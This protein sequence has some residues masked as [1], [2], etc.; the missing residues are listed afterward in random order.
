M[1]DV[2]FYVTLKRPLGLFIQAREID[3]TVLI[4]TLYLYVQCL[5]TQKLASFI[6]IE[7]MFV[8]RESVRNKWICHLPAAAPASAV[9]F[10]STIHRIDHP[11][12]TVRVSTHRIS[13]LST[14][15]N[16]LPCGPSP[17]CLTRPCPGPRMIQSIDT[18]LQS[19]EP[20]LPK[21]PLFA[22]GLFTLGDLRTSQQHARRP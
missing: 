15:V 1:I 22:L 10:A 9:Q 19:L 16:T 14:V 4:E 12:N 3:E 17:T 20:P 21:Q 18:Y 2:L 6:S 8:R 13:L 5:H 7:Q 11:E